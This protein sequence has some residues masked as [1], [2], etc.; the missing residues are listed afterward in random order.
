MNKIQHFEQIEPL[1]L[2][3]QKIIKQQQTPKIT[4]AYNFPLWGIE[5]A[6]K[7]QTTNIAYNTR[8]RIILRRNFCSYL[9]RW[10]YII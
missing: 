6:T 9:Q 5:G 2:F 3:E 1:E 7:H 10:R 8:H 4:T